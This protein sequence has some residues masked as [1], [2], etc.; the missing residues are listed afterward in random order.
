MEDVLNLSESDQ[1]KIYQ[2]IIKM[3]KTRIEKAQSVKKK[4]KTVSGINVVEL[5]KLVLDKIDTELYDKISNLEIKENYKEIE[6]IGEGK[7]SVN[8]D[9]S[10][11]P[12]VKIGDYRIDC[13]SLN[14]AQYVKYY[15]LM[16]KSNIRIP[17]NDENLEVLLDDFKRMD[18]DIKDS[19]KKILEL[20]ASDEKTKKQL[21][22][23]IYNDIWKR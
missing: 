20:T 19:I 9:Y 16:G 18:E 1:F 14:E 5:K 11:I 15:L 17:I 23:F 3:L 7:I 2:S 13:K 8:V 6:I 21:R 4:K 12:H 10:G 22:S